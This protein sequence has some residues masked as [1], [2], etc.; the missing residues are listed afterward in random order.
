MKQVRQKPPPG[1]GLVP[2]RLECERGWSPTW[3][4]SWGRRW[5]TPRAPTYTPFTCRASPP[6]TR[7]CTDV[8]AKQFS[9]GLKVGMTNYIRFNFLM[10]LPTLVPLKSWILGSL[11]ITKKINKLIF[12][13]VT[14]VI[15]RII[16]L[17][18]FHLSIIG[19]GYQKSLA[20]L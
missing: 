4:P 6:P 10:C 14:N 5:S 11:V 3:T 18:D 12:F 15:P 13:Q 7:D 2:T 1:S 8:M 17:V 16:S 19:K 9:S 20:E